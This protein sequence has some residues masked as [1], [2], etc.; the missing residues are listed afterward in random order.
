MFYVITAARNDQKSHYYIPE[1]V[2]LIG[3]RGFEKIY[4]GEFK[5]DI[6]KRAA[7][8]TT[9]AALSATIEVNSGINGSLVAM[10]L[11]EG[12]VARI[13]ECS[14]NLLDVMKPNSIVSNITLSSGDADSFVVGAYTKNTSD[15]KPTKPP[16][17]TTPPLLELP[18]V[19]KPIYPNMDHFEAFDVKSEQ[20]VPFT[21]YTGNW[22]VTIQLLGTAERNQKICDIESVTQRLLQDRGSTIEQNVLREL[23]TVLYEEGM[24]K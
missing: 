10:L 16:K 12:M 13:H 20:W 1:H 5:P 3:S 22:P 19:G 9:F 6:E 18:I 17:V 4:E 7:K 8:F 14:T 15:F 2:L 21:E 23:I 24:L 11:N